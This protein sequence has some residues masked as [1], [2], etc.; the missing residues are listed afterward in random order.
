KYIKLT[1]G[2]RY[3]SLK[4]ENGKDTTYFGDGSFGTASLDTVEAERKGP[5]VSFEMS[6]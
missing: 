3:F 1:A 4:A 5:Y 2:Y 6:F